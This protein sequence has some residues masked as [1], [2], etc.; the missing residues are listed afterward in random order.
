MMNE[1]RTLRRLVGG[2]A[3][4]GLLVSLLA[5]GGG[6]GSSGAGGGETTAATTSGTS[7]SASSSSATAGAG[8]GSAEGTTC[9][10]PSSFI[11]TADLIPPDKCTEGGGTPGPT[12]PSANLIGCCK[13]TAGGFTG[14]NCYYTGEGPEGAL[15]KN[16]DVQ[17]GTWSTTP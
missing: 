17:G 13:V 3:A 2:G 10:L 1:L 14:R 8:G 12:C 6:G 4:L 11:C 5:C 9:Y 15:K 16:C 7:T